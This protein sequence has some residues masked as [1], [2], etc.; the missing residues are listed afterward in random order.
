MCCRSA[1]PR[2]EPW[3]EAIVCFDLNRAE[4]IARRRK[5]GGH[6]FCKGRYPAAQL[7]AY[8][9]GGLWLKLATRANTLAKRLADAAGRWLANPPGANMVFI[10]PGATALAKLRAAGMEFYEGANADEAR[11]VV[12]WNQPEADIARACA[13]LQKL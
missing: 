8:L 7:L 10:N 3:A 1:R 4:E 12:S 5:R 13:L 11:L 2:T 9:E 6:L